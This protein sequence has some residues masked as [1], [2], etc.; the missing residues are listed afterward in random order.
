VATKFRFEIKLLSTGI[1]FLCHSV[2][3]ASPTKIVDQC[4]E[5][6]TSPTFQAELKRAPEDPAFSAGY[7]I[8][9]EFFGVE[10]IGADE[11]DE[12]IPQQKQD[13][14]PGD[15]PKGKEVRGSVFNEL[16]Q[17]EISKLDQIAKAALAKCITA[18]LIKYKAN[19]NYQGIYT[20]FANRNGTCIEYSSVFDSI[21]GSAPFSL[22]VNKASGYFISKSVEDSHSFN[23][24]MLN[25]KMYY[26]EPQSDRPVFVEM[27]PYVRGK[28]NPLKN[29]ELG[30]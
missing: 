13:A 20:T 14:A 16:T 2:F 3:A 28:V 5:M 18:R 15:V 24:I 9:R 1:F 21:A 26:L 25:G 23:A 7:L 11:F 27:P 10:Y 17:F 4:Y 22:Q 19:K 30:F 12:S 6:V 8:N 29:P